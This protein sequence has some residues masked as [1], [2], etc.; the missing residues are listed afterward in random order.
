MMDGKREKKDII[1]SHDDVAEC[2]ATPILRTRRCFS[3][4]QAAQQQ[5]TRSA[6]RGEIS[7]QTLQYAKEAEKRRM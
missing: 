7:T 2:T 5:Y 6:P 4:T 3:Y 1:E